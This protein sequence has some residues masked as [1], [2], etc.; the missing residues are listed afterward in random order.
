M[1]EEFV[2][3]LSRIQ[4]LKRE[5]LWREASAEMEQEFVRLLGLPGQDAANLSET[6]LL[7]R[8]IKSGPTQVIREKTLMLVALLKE[9]GDLA[10]SSSKPEEAR[11]LYLKAL[12]LLLE[13][14]ARHEAFECPGF[15]PQVAVLS[16]ALRDTPLPLDTQARLM[17]HYESIGEFAQAENCLYAMVEA[18]PDTDGLR[19]F[20]IAFY[21]RLQHRTDSELAAG[22]LP[23]A[24]LAAGLTEF[25]DRIGSGN[26]GAVK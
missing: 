19:E 18:A 21:E 3:V 22:N 9:A 1:I 5:Q 2:Q 14:L 24:E 12:N 4:S 7:A 17:R 20:G 10:H 16:D 11:A 23:R 6:E 15:V 25:R 8:L 13:T 26:R